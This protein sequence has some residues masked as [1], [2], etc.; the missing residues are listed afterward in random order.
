MGVGF[1]LGAA[2]GDGVEEEPGTG[3]RSGGQRR[4]EGSRFP[5]GG[6]TKRKPGEKKKNV[7]LERGEIENE[8]GA[9][10]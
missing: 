3:A 6:L 7:F 4:G 10:F 5:P 9:F 1:P 2:A 8:E